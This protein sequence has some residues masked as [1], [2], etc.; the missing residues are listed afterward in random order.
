MPQEPALEQSEHGYR[1][2]IEPFIMAS[3]SMI[4]PG[5]RVLDVGTG[6]GVIAVLLALREEHLKIVCV[7]VQ[8]SLYQHAKAN[9]EK[10]ALSGRVQ[11]FEGD[12]IELAESLDLFDLVISNPPYRKTNTGRINPNQEKAIARHEIKLDL[13]SLVKQGARVLKPGG[14][15]ILAYPPERLAEVLQSL[16]EHGLSPSRLQF[17]H[18]SKQVQA[19]IFLVEAI[20]GTKEDTVVLPP[21]CVYNEN[22]GAERSY[23]PEMQKIYAS[24]N[25]TG[26]SNHIQKE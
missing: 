11:V 7:E 24:F 18:G 4:E 9:I 23:T 8:K 3:F 20:K 10:N 13:E 14:R 16:R 22:S 15:M 2:S 25:Y 12:F 21:L 6:C 26:G 1:Y 5:M 19:K 17:I